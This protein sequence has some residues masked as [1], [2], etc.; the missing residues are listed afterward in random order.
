M[1]DH[2]SLT[3]DLL[4]TGHAAAGWRTLSRRDNDQSPRLD[5]RQAIAMTDV[6]MGRAQRGSRCI[7]VYSSAFDGYGTVCQSWPATS[8][9]A[10][11]GLPEKCQSASDRARRVDESLRRRDG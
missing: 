3:T 1:P 5:V 6:A 7:S 4:G 10:P 2:S 8:T 11:V 9:S